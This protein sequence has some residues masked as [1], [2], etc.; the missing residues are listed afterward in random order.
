MHHGVEPAAASPN[1]SPGLRSFRRGGCSD[2]AT[3][4]NE[5]VAWCTSGCASARACACRRVRTAAISECAKGVRETITEAA[6]L[7]AHFPFAVVPARRP[8][9]HTCLSAPGVCLSAVPHAAGLFTSAGAKTG[10]VALR[11]DKSRPSSSSPVRQE[12]GQTPQA[13]YPWGP[14][15]KRSAYPEQR[16]QPWIGYAFE[17]CLPRHRDSIDCWV[18][19]QRNTIEHRLL[20]PG[21][22]VGHHGQ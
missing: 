13:F 22:S 5:Q 8:S 15:S 19:H 7:Y 16:R 17:A 12:A 20:R 2:P 14:A 21:Q 3:P 10:L 6:G 4:G 18:W 9:R 11:M 1:A